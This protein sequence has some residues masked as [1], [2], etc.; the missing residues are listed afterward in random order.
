MFDWI[1]KPQREISRLRD[2]ISRLHDELDV[3]TR[4]RDD[5]QEAWRKLVATRAETIRTRNKY[6]TLY[7]NESE[8]TQKL[9]AKL[10]NSRRSTECARM[11]RDENLTVILS[12]RSTIRELI[13]ALTKIS[14]AETPRMNGTVTRII[15]IANT[16]LESMNT[17]ERRGETDAE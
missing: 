1:F 2:E 17:P 12:Q 16:A 5:Y 4:S 8:T 15:R 7:A 13:S 10:T 3:K 6:R 14:A 11:R 9:T